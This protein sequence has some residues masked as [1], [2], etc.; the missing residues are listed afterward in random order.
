MLKDKWGKFTGEKKGNGKR[1]ENIC[2]PPWE[3]GKKV[4]TQAR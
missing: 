1:I 3:T 4:M 2:D